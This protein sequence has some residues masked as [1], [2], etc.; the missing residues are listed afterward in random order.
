[1]KKKVLSGIGQLSVE[2]DELKKL[3]DK[4]DLMLSGI[5]EK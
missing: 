3:S 2:W 1:M 5:D 4:W